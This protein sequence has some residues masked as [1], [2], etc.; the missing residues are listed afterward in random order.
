M[1]PDKVHHGKR[2]DIPADTWAAALD[3]VRWLKDCPDTS[4]LPPDQRAQLISAIIQ[5][6]TVELPDSL[7]IT[8]E[9]GAAK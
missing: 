2:H 1:T 9:A 4:K 5:G 7:K 6:K 3:C 8:R